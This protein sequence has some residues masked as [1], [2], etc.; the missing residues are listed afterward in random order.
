MVIGVCAVHQGI[1]VG[2]AGGKYAHVFGM[3][4]RGVN[5]K[6]EGSVGHVEGHVE[7][8]VFVALDVHLLACGEQS[9][10]VTVYG[11]SSLLL[12]S[13]GGCKVGVFVFHYASCV[14]DVGESQVQVVFDGQ[15]EC[16][17]RLVGV[18][19]VRL[20]L[21]PWQVG[22][23]G[24]VEGEVDVVCIVGEYAAQVVGESLGHGLFLHGAQ[25]G[26]QLGGDVGDELQAIVDVVVHAAV[27]HVF[28]DDGA[29][30]QGSEQGCEQG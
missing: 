25:L 4:A 20:V 24:V 8:V 21:V 14:G 10:A 26:A 12:Q 6:S 19:D 15:V 9:C 5:D 23:G 1:A 7:R 2:K 22:T 11:V 17:L 13:G 28:I 29:R 3:I 18:H 30:V 27:A 16:V